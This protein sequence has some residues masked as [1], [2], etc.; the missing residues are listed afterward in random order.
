MKPSTRSPARARPLRKLLICHGA[1]H[2]P[3]PRWY[4]AETMDVDPKAHPTH[5]VD[6]TAPL[7]LSRSYDAIM[8]K[9]CNAYAFFTNLPRDLDRFLSEGGDV[10][11]RP[12]RM[13]WKNVHKLLRGGGRLHVVYLE[14]LYASL[15]ARSERGLALHELV[16]QTCGTRFRYVRDATDAVVWRKGR[17]AS[18]SR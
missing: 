11:L 4:D 5:L 3:V 16:N 12:H 9:N 17:A 10:A 2:K 6:I 8:L 7:T 13:A 14:E 15:D 18:A 1:T